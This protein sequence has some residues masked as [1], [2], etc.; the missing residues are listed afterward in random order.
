MTVL[1]QMSIRLW[2]EGT[3]GLSGTVLVDMAD[4]GL[5]RETS[6]LGAISVAPPTW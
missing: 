4:E 3:S 1:C 5:R 6:A 2:E